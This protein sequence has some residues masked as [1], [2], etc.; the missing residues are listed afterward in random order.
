MRPRKNATAGLLAGTA[1]GL[2]ASWLMLR[3]IQGPGHRLQESLK[4]QDDRNADATEQHRHG[5]TQ[6]ETVTMQAAD[7]FASH[8]PGGRH[9][10]RAEKEQGGTVVHYGFGA[11]M[12]AAYGVVSEYTTLPGIGF[13]TV[14]G[15]V[16]WLNTDLWS[17]P[18]VGFA[19]WPKDEPASAHLSHWLAHVVYATGMETT[20]R[21]L[22]RLV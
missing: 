1:S 12:G 18:A 13:G 15:T 8:L 22:R 10:S 9:L 17:V 7:T 14:F 4:T 6:P 3:F 20:R 5:Q 11:L 21:L 2:V 19:K 16:L